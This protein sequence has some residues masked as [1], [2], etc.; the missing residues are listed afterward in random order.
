MRNRPL[1]QPGR[2]DITAH[3][4]FSALIEAGHTL[5]LDAIG[6]TTQAQFLGRLGIQSEARA[7][8]SRLYPYADSER[9]TDR[10]QADYLRRASLLSAV[11]T[12]LDPNGLGSFHVLIQQRGVPESAWSLV[13][14]ARDYGSGRG[15]SAELPPLK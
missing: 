9:H 10:G 12:L 14:I 8:A 6:F 11:S 1:A 4:D 2:Q 15:P 13:G 5:G 7:L 3:V